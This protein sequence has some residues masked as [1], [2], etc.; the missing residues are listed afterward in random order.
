MNIDKIQIGTVIDHIPHGEGLKLVPLLRLH[1][2]PKIVSIGLN[3]PSKKL[4][5]KDLI[6][7][8][9]R[10]FSEDELDQIA[11]LAPEATISLIEKGAVQKKFAVKLP[12]KVENLYTCRNTNCITRGEGVNSSFTL[13]QT[14][15]NLILNCEFC[16]TPWQH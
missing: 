12:E 16:G 10:F 8:E 11:L 14:S 9:G 7:V 1:E 2:L 3:L 13:H 4:G 15:S 6:K 5:T